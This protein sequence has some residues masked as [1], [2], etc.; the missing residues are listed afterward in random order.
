MSRKKDIADAV[1]AT[2]RGLTLTGGIMD[3]SD[4]RVERLFKLSDIG[5]NSKFPCFAV[6]T[7]DIG[8]T[9]PQSRSATE[10]IGYGIGVALFASGSS[11]QNEDEWEVWRQAMQDAFRNRRL[12]G[13]P[14]VVRCV[15][16]NGPGLNPAM[17]NFDKIRGNDVVRCIYQRAKE[18]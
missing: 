4:V 8:E 7:A 1:E 9:N 17:D 6:Y 11:P 10:D 18:A 12:E 2:I 14:Q 16:E 13:V 5:L 3:G 15:L